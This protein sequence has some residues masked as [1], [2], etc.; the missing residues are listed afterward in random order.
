MLFKMAVALFLLGSALFAY[1]GLVYRRTNCGSQEEGEK[2]LLAS[3]YRGF[4]L[5]R[6]LGPFWL[7]AAGIILMLAALITATVGVCLRFGP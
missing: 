2:D 1:A 3:P 4:F 5:G 7:A 6:R